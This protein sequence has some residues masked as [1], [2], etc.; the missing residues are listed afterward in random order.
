MSN[1]IIL[2]ASSRGIFEFSVVFQKRKRKIVG[3]TE[4]LNS[5]AEFTGNQQRLN[6]LVQL[7]LVRVP[8]MCCRGDGACEIPLETIDTVRFGLVFR[9]R[10]RL[11]R[12]R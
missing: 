5:I 6:H 2:I 4:I 8:P 10:L 3:R 9:L 12:V 11:F 7:K 1:E